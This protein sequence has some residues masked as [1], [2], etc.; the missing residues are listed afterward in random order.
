M[1]MKD[2]SRWFLP[3][4]NKKLRSSMGCSSRHHFPSWVAQLSLLRHLSPRQCLSLLQRQN[5]LLSYLWMLRERESLLN[6]QNRQYLRTAFA[7]QTA[8]SFRSRSN[9]PQ[10]QKWLYSELDMTLKGCPK[11]SW[12]NILPSY[13]ILLNF[14]D[15][16]GNFWAIGM[17]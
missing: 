12:T 3:S 14:V 10:P 6:H 1:A 16:V 15:F 5:H 2:S 9:V 4:G 11:E 13:V 17:T 7:A 8:M